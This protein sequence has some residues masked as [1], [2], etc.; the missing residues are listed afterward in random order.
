M[1][2]GV[3]RGHVVAAFFQRLEHVTAQR[4]VSHGGLIAHHEGPVDQVLVDDAKGV[5]HAPF[6]PAHHRKRP[7]LDIS[8]QPRGRN[9]THKAIPTNSH[10]A[11]TST[12]PAMLRGLA[13][14]VYI[15]ASAWPRHS[16]STSGGNSCNV[17]QIK[18]GSISTSST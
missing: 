9:H 7:S 17:S 2:V 15:Q 10:N 3:A 11:T 13:P 16:V 4:K 14:W 1:N 5:V 18:L 12:G 8:R 6:Q